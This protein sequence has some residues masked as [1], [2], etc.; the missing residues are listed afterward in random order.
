MRKRQTLIKSL[1]FLSFGVFSPFVV[2]FTK[3]LL[4]EKFRKSINESAQKIPI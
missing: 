1:P 3:W 2:T 4:S